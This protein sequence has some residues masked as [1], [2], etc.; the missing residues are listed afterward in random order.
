MQE[1]AI[2]DKVI[3]VQCCTNKKHETRYVH[4]TVITS[5][6]SEEMEVD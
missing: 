6:I 2:R 3:I 4:L 5:G 1:N